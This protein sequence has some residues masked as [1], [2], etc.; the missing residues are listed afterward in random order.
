VVLDVATIGYPYLSIP[1]A[2]KIV[3]ATPLWVSQKIKT[4]DVQST[5]ILGKLPYGSKAN[6]TFP[7]FRE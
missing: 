1:D 5:L 7:D 2:D 4:Y 6:A 3:N